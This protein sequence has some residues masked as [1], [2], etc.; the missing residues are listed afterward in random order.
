[1]ETIGILL[2]ILKN[3]DAIAGQM[4]ALVK[5]LDMA[6]ICVKG[7]KIIASDITE[8]LVA[9]LKKM[10][11][12]R[13]I[14]ETLYGKLYPGKTLPESI[15]DARLII[16]Q[17]IREIELE[18]LLAKCKRFLSLGA[19]NAKAEA[20]LLEK[21]AS[22]QEILDHFTEEQEAEIKP[23]GMFMD[24]IAETDATKLV[25]YLVELSGVFG[26]ELLGKAMIRKE[27]YQKG[28]EWV[29]TE[30]RQQEGIA[31]EDSQGQTEAEDSQGESVKEDRQ[32]QT[33][34]ED[35]QGESVKEDSQEWTEAEDSQEG[36]A[37]EGRQRI[38]AQGGAV[39]EGAKEPYNGQYGRIAEEC[40]KRNQ[41]RQETEALVGSSG[42]EECQ[43]SQKTEEFTSRNVEGERQGGQGKEKFTGSN[44]EERVQDRQGRKGFTSEASEIGEGGWAGGNSF[45]ESEGSQTE[46]ING[47][48][49]LEEEKTEAV[50]EEKTEAEPEEKTNAASEE[51]DQEEKKK[52]DIQGEIKAH[53]LLVSEEDF[54][55]SFYANISEAEEK[56]VGAKIFIRDMKVRYAA[57]NVV[58]M[59]CVDR[60]NAITPELVAVSVEA[61]LEQIRYS[62]QYLQK[63]GYIREYGVEGIGAFYCI[64]PK[65][66]KALATKDAR[67][68]LRMKGKPRDGGEEISDALIPVLTRIAYAK[69]LSIYLEQMVDSSV[70]VYDLVWTECFG[71]KMTD[72]DS[73]KGYV[74]IGAFWKEA[75]EAD[76]FL[77]ILEENYA[78]QYDSFVITS[79]YPEIT[80]N[81]AKYLVERLQLE[82][83]KVYCYALAE[84]RLTAYG[85]NVQIPF[86]TL[87]E[88]AEEKEE[89]EE[90]EGTVENGKEQIPHSGYDPVGEE[91]KLER[92]P[93][94]KEQ[95]T[96]EKGSVKQPEDKG[97][98]AETN[99]S[100]KPK[101]TKQTVE[102]KHSQKEPK[103]KEQA[104]EERMAFLISSK[105]L[106]HA[107]PNV[108]QMLIDRKAYCAVTYLRSLA[109]RDEE[110][111]NAH[112]RLA[113]ALN[114]PWMCCSYNSD[115]IFT[116]YPGGVDAFTSYL[117]VA[118]TLRNF[119]LNH[120]SFDYMMKP[121]YA[122][123]K[124]L[125]VVKESAALTNVLYQI[126]H[127]KEE[128]H[129]G[130]DVYA[131]YK[132]KD[133]VAVEREL[134]A[135][136]MEA[137]SYY[138][139]Y[140][141]G[142]I[143]ENASNARFLE[144]RKVVFA[145]DG[146]LSGY[147]QAVMEKD[148]S[149]AEI[150]QDSL[151]ETFICENCSVEYSNL[152]SEKLDAFV[153]E[154]WD[155]AGEKMRQTARKTSDLIGS[156]RN[157][158]VNAIEK[159]LRVICRWIAL[160]EKTNTLKDEGSQRYQEVKKD[161]LE[162]I[163]EASAGLRARRHALAP[164]AYAG[165]VVLEDTLLELAA[166]LDGAYNET[167]YRYF[168]IDFL[169]GNE[170]LLEE[171]YF[172]DMR[173]K[174]FD[175]QGLSL[176]N[177]I[178]RH[179]NA[180]LMTFEE[181]LDHIFNQYGDDYGSAELI[182]RYLEDMG[183]M[184]CSELYDMEASE[185][186]AQTDA[187]LRLDDFIENLELAQSY[188]Q[189]E[190]ARENKKERIQK[191]A[192]EWFIYAKESKNYGFFKMVLEKYR[193]KIHEDAK[194]RGK[195]LLKELDGIKAQGT[196]DERMQSRI[197]D[198]QEMIENQNYTV[199]EDLLSRIHSDEP[200]E[201]IEVAGTDYLEQFIE[202]Y[203]YNYKAV[204]D[205]SCKMSDLVLTRMRNKDVRG[206]KRLAEQWMSNGHYLGPQRLVNL[207]DALGFVGA[208][209]KEHPKIGKLENYS[210]TIKPPVG[211][212]VNY[213]H[214]IAA[215][216]SKACNDGFRVVCL[217]GRY[218][219]DRLIEE[220]KNIG[221]SKNTLVLLDF[222][223]PLA[224]RR[225]L[226]RKIKS[227]L[228]DKVFAV[229]D[230]VLLMFLINHY[231]VQFMNQIL[232]SVMMPFSY[233]Q[234]YVWDSSKIMPPEIFMGRK[235]ELEKIE[236][237]AGVNIV[238]GGRQLGKS[239]LLKMAKRDID[240]DENHNRAVLVEI[241]G[242][243]AA[244][245]AQKIGH[246]LFDAGVLSEDIDT[247]DWDV[248]GR[249]IRQRLQNPSLPY[250]PYLLL[251]LDEADAFIESCEK[252]KF[253]P[254]DVLKE[255]QG[256]GEDR[257][258]F[259]IA[260]LHNIV[261]F[262]RDAALSGNS[263]LT[264]LTSI[265]VKPFGIQ[266]ARLLLEK[267]LYYLGFRFPQDKQS[268]VSLILAN[269]NY[270]PGLIQLYCANLVEAMRK[271]DYAGYD[272]I[273]TPAYE[274]RE[275][276]IKKVLSDPSFM[277]Q[278]REKFEITLKL[279][280]DNM[281]YIIA[282]LMAYL[283]HQNTNCAS[284]SEG[285]SA[286][287]I[288]Y[289]GQEYGIKKIVSSNPD[290]VNGWMQELM[291]LN[292][293]RQTVDHLYLFSRY[294]FFQMM[295]TATEVEDKLLEYMEG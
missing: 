280:E 82:P 242:L 189:I 211:R 197:Q 185:Q 131:D 111:R 194:I 80:E 220:F 105:D 156:L 267:P 180:G 183:D 214:P 161:I 132:L 204:A 47:E 160:A 195:A 278:I 129:K 238:Y 240:R 75:D 266:E 162:S 99:W 91:K 273:N 175:F 55:G 62:F 201:A 247:T 110:I 253:Y 39:K 251:L 98:S 44:E 199:A 112:E 286:E 81:L 193:E 86:L 141:E 35:K 41:S 96:E 231:N 178:L 126:H 101:D 84:D 291:E 277:E 146:D 153:N 225:R 274:I 48:T 87:F 19:D 155:K 8:R 257:F 284:E 57:G 260:G 222:S 239:A 125:P 139:S 167:S 229:L 17:A 206:A 164:D 22:L 181:K 149:L 169:R 271:E 4:P 137:K 94:D 52:G 31:K 275:N 184:S 36:I 45:R 70:E 250:I 7:K 294:S 11:Q 130:I 73:G 256:I 227:D 272:Q 142:H 150:V 252:E 121:L 79:L 283:Y 100:E 26:N 27:I 196:M 116:L 58:S 14:C 37:K 12:R 276:H 245:A 97:Q 89:T 114:D 248:L 221:G 21:K 190:E 287:D 219:A 255:I 50:P 15:E 106:E 191:I 40:K 200:E 182:L 67:T 289:A 198:I 269:T 72:K 78:D 259:V 223:L 10:D 217:L 144:T 215:F 93:E 107:M 213:K 33:E 118:A 235:D 232:M 135:L 282:L 230:R 103:D 152:D 268:L 32:E 24:A 117:M 285:F 25:G 64:S 9:N 18:S 188:G 65:G 140:V 244:R 133:Q 108:Y 2:E 138:D 179:A 237:P 113:F 143:K 88:G 124:E 74:F 102:E 281:Y 59:K 262:R 20:L 61:P 216:G 104:V 249:S 203:D 29:E 119:F 60:Y 192:S 16:T 43:D 157:N 134:D 71:I 261:R 243:D 177:R 30:D 90:T 172:P 136:A 28:Q 23:F 236:S 246:E 46:D 207:L 77:R 95:T 205:S 166:R 123:V 122:N 292:I 212:K 254:F 209:V 295:G 120:I 1:M 234:P 210:V 288:I 85:N 208:E 76:I 158:I 233:Y 13:D 83:D 128:I 92:E 165:S 49:P 224:E 163:A 6:V 270:F 228:N 176:P 147:L 187:K 145:K 56:K 5:E 38:T 241:K 174:F 293:L 68:F 115:K 154:A 51:A 186:I 170:V 69:L 279:D 148:Y 226:A 218:D 34:A 263:V 127:F 168:Y 66:E 171:D 258:K 109:G 54:P 63:K 290:A 151:K 173:G 265:T 202:E 53:G 3:M 42:E 264:Q 159:T